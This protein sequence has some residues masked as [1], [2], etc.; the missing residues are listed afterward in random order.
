MCMLCT[1]CAATT[2]YPALEQGRTGC[3]LLM[4]LYALLRNPIRYAT[5]RDASSP[6]RQTLNCNIS[7]TANDARGWVDEKAGK[8]MKKKRLENEN[9]HL[10]SRA[11]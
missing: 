1:A 8:N 11:N 6:P 10:K 5:V 7:L 3:G 9:S 2:I 4:S